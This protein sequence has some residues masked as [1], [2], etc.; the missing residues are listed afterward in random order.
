MKKLSEIMEELG[1]RPEG[2]EDVK[3]A[4][5]KNLIKQAHSGEFGSFQVKQEDEN[6][7]DHDPDSFEQMSLFDKKDPSL[8]SG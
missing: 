5:V 7:K 4:F 6:S 3:K 2:S 1:F 8:R